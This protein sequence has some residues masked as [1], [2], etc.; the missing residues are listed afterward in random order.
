MRFPDLD[1]VWLFRRFLTDR[2][3]QVGRESVSL[4][5]A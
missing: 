4:N 2:D 3:G 5:L 1:G